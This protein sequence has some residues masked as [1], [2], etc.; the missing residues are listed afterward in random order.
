VELPC[1]KLQGKQSRKTQGTSQTQISLSLIIKPYL[2]VLYI[3]AVELEEQTLV[4]AVLIR[5]VEG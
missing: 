3:Q 1:K 5:M 4:Q 2:V